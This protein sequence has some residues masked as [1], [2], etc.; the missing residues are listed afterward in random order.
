M[1]ARYQ[2]AETPFTSLGG[3]DIPLILINGE[4]DLIS[5]PYLLGL[6]NR[7][8][9]I[10]TIRLRATAIIDFYRFCECEGINFPHMMSSLTN[11]QIGQLEALSAFLMANRA[12]GELV[13]EQT[14]RAKILTAKAFIYFWWDTYQ[15][16]ASNNAQK[17]EHAKNKRLVMEKSFQLLEKTPWNATQKTQIGLQPELRVLFWEIINPYSELNPFKYEA[18]KWR[19]YVMFLTLGLGGNR[20][21]ES[22]LLRLQDVQVSGREKY[23][24]VVK[25]PIKA[26]RK[27]GHK[28][29]PS[30]KTKGR[31]V[32]LTDDIAEIFKHYIVHERP[33]FRGHLSTDFL[34]LSTKGG[35]PL[36]LR[37]VNHMT[38]KIID[39][40]P[41]FTGVLSPHRLRNTFHDLL[42]DAIDSQHSEQQHMSP[43]MRESVKKSIQEYAGGWAHGSQMTSHYPAGSIERKVWQM[44]LSAQTQSLREYSDE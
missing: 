42:H 32:A 37:S 5:A 10:G 8:Q 27:T 41:A 39:K 2:I 19:N 6:L 35:K 12:T 23:F 7:N 22:V 34:F 13:A 29:N 14:Y 33:Q 15:S 11:F 21:G 40:Y 16:R 1:K 4:V 20:R 36:S 43:L 28:I 3:H 25:D 44:T 17:L 30:P 24:E 18:T 26:P 38:S 9:T 31:K